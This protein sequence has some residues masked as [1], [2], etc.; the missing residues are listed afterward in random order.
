MFKYSYNRIK[1]E[2][3]QLIECYL[4]YSVGPFAKRVCHPKYL[5]ECA[6]LESFQ[7][8]DSCYRAMLQAMRKKGTI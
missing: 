4:G 5:K 6:K 3:I 2:E 8:R 7:V 1:K